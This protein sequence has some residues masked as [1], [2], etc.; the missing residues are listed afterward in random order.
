MKQFILLFSLFLFSISANSATIYVTNTDDSGVGSLREAISVANYGD[1]VRVNSSLLSAGS[2][3]INLLSTITISKGIFIK[4][5]FNSQD[6]LYINGG[7]SI[8][9]FR[10]E[11]D[12]NAPLPSV[13]F[14]SLVCV[15]GKGTYGGAININ[16]RYDYGT[17][18]GVVY[19]RNCVFKNNQ[20]DY[21]GA[22][23]SNRYTTS[24][25]AASVK[26]Q[27]FKT[28]IINNS[29]INDGGGIYL[30]MY[31]SQGP[32]ARLD[33]KLNSCNII[34]NNAGGSGG[35]IYA[36]SY[37][38]NGSTTVYR[39]AYSDVEVN[40][41]TLSFNN[42]GISGGGIYCYALDN[43]NAHVANASV[44]LKE[45]TITNNTAISNGGAV[46]SFCNDL[47]YI[48]TKNCT[49]LYNT[50]FV[51]GGAF[52]LKS[53]STYNVQSSR[54]E[55]QTVSSILAF[56]GGNS[57]YNNTV[58]LQGN[59]SYINTNSYNIFDV[60]D[61][62]FPNYYLPFSW[63]TD[64]YS[65]TLAQINLSSL[66]IND[67]NT[68]SMT[69]NLGS[70]AVN[71]GNLDD[72]D[73]AQNGALLG[74]R[75]VGAA[76]SAFCDPIPVSQTASICSGSTYDFYG[77]DLTSAGTYNYTIV[78]PNQCD[79]NV[80]LTL[81]TTAPVIPTI[82]ITANP[83]NTIMVGTPVTITATITNGG[84]AP[85][86]Q[87]YAN[88]S[89]I[90]PNAS[91]VI[92][93]TL[94]N[95][96]QVK[97]IVASNSVCVSPATA[98]SNIITFN[99][100][101]NNDEPCN[102]ITIAT[103]TTCVTSYF[104]NHIATETTNVG[105]HSCA[106]STSNDIWFK[107][108]APASGF[109]NIYTYSG[110]L[111][112]AVMSVYLGANCSSLFE[113]G[114]VDDDG[115]NQM[116]QGFVSGATPGTTYYIRVS[117]YGTTAVGNFA[118]CL[119]EENSQPTAVNDIVS[120]AYNTPTTIAVLSNDSDMGG[121]LVLSTL[122]ISSP[123]SNGIAVIN[124]NGTITFTPNPGFS[125]TST[126][127]YQI[128]DN[129]TPALC[130][131][132]TV[133]I[134]VAPDSNPVANNDVVST[135]Y[136]TPITINVLSNDFDLVGNLVNSSLNIF[137]QSVNGIAVAN[138]N[139]TITFT[140]NDGFSGVTTFQY[141][142]CDNEVLALCATAT[143][144]VT[145]GNSGLNEEKI[146]AS[147]YPNPATNY[148]TF[149]TNLNVK[150]L[151]IYSLEGKLLKDQEQFEIIDIKDFSNGVYFIELHFENGKIS[152]NQ[153]VKQ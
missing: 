78:T 103:N 148:L 29:A 90:G 136:L 99:V 25:N 112:D 143:V 94:T 76:E 77:Q 134:N 32:E 132:A 115:T 150:S 28:S 152:R 75:D 120:T 129:G 58:Y 72:F 153:F 68:F 137:V 64:T 33:L 114:C 147:I 131:T 98:Q 53:T 105:A 63:N 47:S 66:I 151:K 100:H 69:P 97:C 34:N 93:S 50:C 6:T 67:N 51:D 8:Q 84:A 16:Y 124:G 62:Y 122:T 133:T 44:I 80:T 107:F 38:Y 61:T 56:N 88:G 45:S 113:V 121:S 5:A 7:D 12:F 149:K 4:G 71:N 14:D 73:L 57:N 79:T 82:T 30:N 85:S 127:Q 116:P 111:T 42:S 36:Y 49:T 130:A 135:A 119:V 17:G 141:Q 74:V 142:I 87:W 89:P 26:L 140:P 104:A 1:I 144:T 43:T 91:S 125:G 3:A 128:C 21:G 138:P 81:T 146:Y 18:I 108:V 139:G 118:I 59:A 55:F 11:T 60:S 83:G 117:S 109:V 96:V 70:I 31:S 52:Y 37:I 95:G 24:S 65:A 10:I 39:G 2:N 48:Y 123:S 126:F 54:A 27:L 110:T 22:I 102:A 40:S 23:A 20:A 92:S 13:D 35:G 106:T 145:V 15:H 86:Y 9:L 41:S 101:A 19:L 46:Y